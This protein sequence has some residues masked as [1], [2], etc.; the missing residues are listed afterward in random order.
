M[1]KRENIDTVE[2]R[3]MVEASTEV[4]DIEQLVTVWPI[5]YQPRERKEAENTVKRVFVGVDAQGQ[6]QSSGVSC[7]VHC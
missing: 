6:D 1:K 4:I 5:A 7:T 2:E 3:K